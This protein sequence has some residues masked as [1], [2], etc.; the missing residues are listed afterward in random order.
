MRLHNTMSTCCLTCRMSRRHERDTAGAVLQKHIDIPQVG[1][2]AHVLPAVKPPAMRAG[3]SGP[4]LPGLQGA[5]CCTNT[6]A[7]SAHM[8]HEQ[9]PRA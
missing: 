1:A 5:K 2:S 3:F 7:L 8:L 9:R 4:V 6:V